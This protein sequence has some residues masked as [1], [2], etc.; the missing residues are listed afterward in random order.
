VDSIEQ[1]WTSGERVPIRLGSIER[2]IFVQRIG[3]GAPMTMLHGYPSSSHD[4]AKTAPALA[5]RHSLLL[6]DFLGFGASEKPADHVYSLHEQADLIEAIWALDE[7]TSTVIVAYD[8]GLSV[9]QE[10]LARRAEHALSVDIR[11]VHLLNG[12]LY[13]DLARPSRGQLAMLDAERGP[14]I[15]AGITEERFV[16]ALRPTF[17]ADYDAAADIA[18]IWR[19]TARQDGHAIAHRLTRYIAD[20]ALHDERWV[21]ALEQTDVPVAFLW[22][23]LDPVSGAHMAQ[24]IRKRLPTAPFLELPDVGHWPPLETPGRVA[25]ALLST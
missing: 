5:Q 10:L 8:Y 13:P 16:R 19:A 3:S 24:Q 12:G 14:Q 15:S 20:R 11:A 1:W 18:D 23:M 6:P 9:T 7:I 22:G 2:A 25:A 21:T 17:A 4:W